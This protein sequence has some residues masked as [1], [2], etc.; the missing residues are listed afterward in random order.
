MNVL[1]FIHTHFIY[2]KTE[3]NL[4]QIIQTSII[5]QLGSDINMF[6][7]NIAKLYISQE[8]ML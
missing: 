4:I 1:E 8:Y 5:W 6:Q 2:G 3:A 7:V